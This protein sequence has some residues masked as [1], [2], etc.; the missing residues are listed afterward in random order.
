VVG[1][2]GDVRNAG[3]Q[4][5]THPEV[6][7]P[8]AQQPL[9]DMSLVVRTRVSPEAMTEEIRHTVLAVDP[10]QPVYGVRTM[11][12]VV[13]EHLAG[14][15]FDTI[16]LS[17]FAGLALLLAVVG[18]YSVMSHDVS[19]RRCEVGL[20]MALGAD[21]GGVVRLF[22][23]R[24]LRLAA[25]GAVLGGLVATLATRLLE[26]RLYAVAPTDPATY[27][28]GAL[29]LVLVAAVACAL[30]ALRAGRVQPTEALSD[31]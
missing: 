1:V 9:H 6:Y 28:A 13:T 26:T 27:G 18:V 29:L 5:A 30:P 3:L 21:R 20:R 22:L 12:Q 31:E 24:G 2:V 8:M 14:R 4:E 25:A 10:L 23:G 16:L 11:R 17:A 7:F 15:S 19:L